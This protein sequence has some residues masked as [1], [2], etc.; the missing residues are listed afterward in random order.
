M[1]VTTINPATTTT[2]YGSLLGPEVWAALAAEYLTDP[3]GLPGHAAELRERAARH[4]ARR[5]GRYVR[6]QVDQVVVTIADADAEIPPAYGYR[7]ACWT[8]VAGQPYDG[9]EDLSLAV[10]SGSANVSTDYCAHPVWDLDTNLRF[11]IWHDTA[12]VEHRLGF[13]TDDELRLFGVQAHEVSAAEV[14]GAEVDAL[15]CESVYQLAAFVHLGS[16]PDVQYV[17][18]LGPVGLAVRDLLLGLTA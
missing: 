7:G 2:D 11:R 8:P 1:T 3:V 18:T 14:F 6:A 16:Y 5:L 10:V 4:Q 9:L 13:G 15:F 12:H 17:R